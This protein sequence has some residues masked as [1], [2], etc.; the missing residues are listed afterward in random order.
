[1]NTKSKL[2]V[3]LAV[4]VLVVAV[5]AGYLLIFRGEASVQRYLAKG[6]SAMADG[7]YSRAI[8]N[9]SAALKMQEE[10]PQIAI[11][12]AG[13]YRGAG[14]YTKA[15]Y[16]L[17]RSISMNP[18]CTQLY[19]AL[20]RT[21]VE[22]EKFMDADKLLTRA[23]SEKVRQELNDMR[24]DPPMLTPDFGY[25][26][27]YI[28][29]SASCVAGRIYLTTDGTVPSNKSH[30]YSEP[31]A[32]EAGETVIHALVVDD[33][34]LVSPIV[35]GGYTVAGLI[36]PIT[37][38]D[39]GLDSLLRGLLGK[40]PEDV[41]MTSELWSITTLTL[42]GNISDLSQL[43]HMIGLESVTVGN[44]RATDLSALSSLPLLRSLDLSGYILS[45]ENLKTIGEMTNLTELYLSSCAIT[46]VDRLSNLK[47]LTVLDLSNNVISDIMPLTQMTALTSLDLSNN[48]LT[49][50]QALQYCSKLTQLNLV[51][52]DIT[53]LEALS[54][55]NQLTV[56][57]VSNNDI[58]SLEH[59]ANCAKLQELDFS[60][61]MVTDIAVLT[62][63]RELG[64]IYGSH[65]EISV[66]PAFSGTALHT[67][68]LSY[69]KI[70]AVDGLKNLMY[71]NYLVLDYNSVKDLLPIENCY[72]LVQVDVWN[73]P[74]TKE[75]VDALASHSI[76]VN[77]N[78]NYKQ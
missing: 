72:N 17:A 49:S 53:S 28:T 57:N 26:S 70:S 76:I 22:Q 65:N 64:K 46:S 61:N 48:P 59:L 6:D 69:N 11:S 45:S 35:Y 66:I 37:I 43:T 38:T 27:D 25:Y 10:D 52:A 1:M 15:E 29:V 54:G 9:Y 20:S 60:D 3:V 36:E 30:L 31:L 50:L 23:A 2:I 77:Y 47:K 55:M 63:L 12:L 33:S 13:A 5:L 24:P 21:Y 14:N 40:A 51:N 41:I 7:N 39:P 8:S 42:D 73:N 18:D 16:T 56:L 67:I 68:D 32:L 19:V 62:G 4:A 78:P 44:I 74:V 75:S 34:G 58:T 71:L